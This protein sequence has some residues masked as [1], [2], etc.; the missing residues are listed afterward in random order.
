MYNTK[1]DVVWEHFMK[2]AINKA[3]D[4]IS[5]EYQHKLTPSMQ[6]VITA[7]IAVQ[8]LWNKNRFTCV[9]CNFLKIASLKNKIT[10]F[11]YIFIMIPQILNSPCNV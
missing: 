1:W 9:Y 6:K 7:V 3:Q 4:E 10:N 5:P 11:F 8:H 2:S